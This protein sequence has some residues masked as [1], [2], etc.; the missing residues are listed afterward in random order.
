MTSFEEM[1]NNWTPIFGWTKVVE[2]GV[3]G[4][5]VLP[6]LLPQEG[7]HV[8][9]FWLDKDKNEEWIPCIGDGC[10]LIDDRDEEPR[11]FCQLGYPAPIPVAWMDYPNLPDWY[12]ESTDGS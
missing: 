7:E 5:V 4:Y 12:L 2:N 9:L 10:W 8:I 1:K 6:A 3:P 11:W